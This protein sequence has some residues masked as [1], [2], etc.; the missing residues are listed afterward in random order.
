M[1]SHTYNIG[2]R[3]SKASLRRFQLVIIFLLSMQLDI[4][5][6]EQSSREDETYFINEDYK[7]HQNL[8]DISIN[9]KRIQ[10]RWHFYIE[11]T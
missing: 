11:L 2:N 6:F 4:S 9:Q 5:V 8:Y 1:Y 10:N 7:H 3:L